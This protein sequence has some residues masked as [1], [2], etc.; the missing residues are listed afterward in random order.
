MIN[1]KHC[2][3]EFEPKS[4]KAEFCSPKCRV[5][6][7]R[8]DNTKIDLEN[9]APNM[10]MNMNTLCKTDVGDT[11][12]KWVTEI[13]EICSKEGIAPEKFIE[14]WQYYQKRE[15]EYIKNKELTNKTAIKSIPNISSP[16]SKQMK[17]PPKGSNAY[18]LRFGKWE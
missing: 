14:K 3:K 10:I 7:R 18:F 11:P 13:E 16:K 4:K 12:K 5:Y 9:N 17:E 8:G 1:C 15:K 2:N 6:F